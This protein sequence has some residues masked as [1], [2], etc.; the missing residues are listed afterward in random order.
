MAA[1]GADPDVSEPR[2]GR[3]SAPGTFTAE[4]QAKF[5]E[6]Y[7]QGRTTVRKCAEA[8]GVSHV[9]VFNHARTNAEFARR[10]RVAIQTNTDCLEDLMMEHVFDREHAGSLTALFGMLKARRPEVWR[11]VHK[12]EHA[13]QLVMVT[14][15]ALA[16]ARQRMQQPEQLGA[17]N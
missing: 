13:G 16:Q 17:L 15:D 5:L 7:E 12:V 8:V 4:K 3:S 10:Y 6:L 11:E 1:N 14:A 2:K 9:T